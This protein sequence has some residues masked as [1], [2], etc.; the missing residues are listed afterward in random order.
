MGLG[1]GRSHTRCDE[2]AHLRA[3]G[4]GEANDVLLAGHGGVLG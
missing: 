1:A 2:G 4:G 3:L